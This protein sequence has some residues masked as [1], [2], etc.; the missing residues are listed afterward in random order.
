MALSRSL[1]CPNP[2]RYWTGICCA[3]DW[4]GVTDTT[5]DWPV[6][7]FLQLLLLGIALSHLLLTLQ[8]R[9]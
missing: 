8:R 9:D 2:N 5:R 3:S 4:K 6:V 1:H 7:L